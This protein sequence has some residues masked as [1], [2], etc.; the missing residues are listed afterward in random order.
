MC[1]DCPRVSVVKEQVVNDEAMGNDRRVQA[2]YKTYVTHL[3]KDEYEALKT[4]LEPI[5]VTL[6]FMDRQDAVRRFYASIAATAACS[7]RPHDPQEQGSSGGFDV[8]QTQNP[9]QIN[10]PTQFFA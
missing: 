10:S 6:G 9:H 2:F 1:H 5:D 7:I 3:T 8:G 4:A